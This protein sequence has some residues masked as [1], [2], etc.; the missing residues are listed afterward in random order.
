L[1]IISNYITIGQNL[2]FARPQGRASQ[3][4]FRHDV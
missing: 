3:G 2:I 4:S 1:Q